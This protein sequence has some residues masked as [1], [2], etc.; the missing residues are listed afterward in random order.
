MRTCCASWGSDRVTWDEFGGRLQAT[1][2]ELTERC[3]LIVSA[4]GRGGYVQFVAEA[5]EL[6]AEAAGPEFTV[7]SAAHWADD[8]AMLV[9]GW[10]APIASAPNWTAVLALPAL[11]AEYAA[12]VDRCVIALRDVYRLPGPEVLSYHAWREPESQPPGVTWPAEQIDRLDP[13]EDP[14][15]LPQLGLPYD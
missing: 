9:A 5:D 12:L 10:T 3:V 4:P 8:P 13:G 7:D 6:T 2:R 11:T 1:L 15:R 14:L